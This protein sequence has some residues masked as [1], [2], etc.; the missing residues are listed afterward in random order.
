M[1]SKNSFFISNAKA[2]FALC[3]AFILFAGVVSVKSQVSEMEQISKIIQEVSVDSQ[4]GAIF[5]YSYMMKVSYEN[6]KLG[7]R[8]FTR[9][10]EAVIPA[11]FS[12]NR[13]YAHPLI[14]LRDSEKPISDDAIRNTRKMIAEEIIK[15]ESEAEKTPVDEEKTPKDGGY[16]TMGFSANQRRIEVNIITLLKGAFLSN[17]QR[18]QVDGRNIVTIDFAP[19]PAA[20]FK[21]PLSYL[22]K[23]EGQIWIDETDKRIIRVEGYA[24]GYLDQY[25]DKPEAERLKEAVFLYSQAKVSE[26]FWF[27]QNVWFNF[28]KHPEIF[29]DFE[30]QYTFSEYKKGTV[31]IQYNEDKAKTTGATSDKQ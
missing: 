27:P 17:L 29:A 7:G 22:E 26:G 25:K 24:I 6:H 28:S 13:I 19:N 3:I 11:R 23:I 8:R 4:R 10:Y 31:E 1:R 9:L 15:A 5:S 21:K 20:S 30:V 18:K 12:L 2:A 14:L 16:W